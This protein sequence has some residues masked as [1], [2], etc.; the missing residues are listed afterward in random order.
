MATADRLVQR[1]DLDM[2]YLIHRAIRV[3]VNAFNEVVPALTFSGQERVKRLVDWYD[4]VQRAV[5][6]HHKGEDAVICPMLTAKRP[7]FAEDQARL[8]EQHRQLTTFMREAG[9]ALEELAQATDAEFTQKR[10]ETAAKF[11]TL[12]E[13]MDGHLGDEE[14]KSLLPCAMLCM[15]IKEMKKVERQ[16]AKETSFSD[17][18]LLLPWVLSVATEEEKKS[19]GDVI[20]WFIMLVYR[21]FWKRKFERLSSPLKAA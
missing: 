9:G 12:K 7:E 3:E 5:E 20:P 11:H 1:S 18:A 21:W 10:D 16:G 13:Y 6:L 15:T 17:L 19:M 2:V 14:D 8:A 4:F